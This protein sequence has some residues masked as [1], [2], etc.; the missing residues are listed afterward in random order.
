M[1]LELTKTMK[2]QILRIEDKEGYLFDWWKAYEIEA[3][4][5]K[6]TEED[7]EGPPIQYCEFEKALKELKNR[8]TPRVNGIPAKFLVLDDKG[9]MELFE[10]CNEIVSTVN[11]HKSL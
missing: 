1:P 5:E 6:I 3:D 11:G 10:I 4:L 2:K 8:N 7:T 9:K